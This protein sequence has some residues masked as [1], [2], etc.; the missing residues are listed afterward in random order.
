M[1]KKMNNSRIVLSLSIV[2]LLVG[3]FTSGGMAIGNTMMDELPNSNNS[4]ASSLGQNLSM[5]TEESNVF[6][7]DNQSQTIPTMINNNLTNNQNSSSILTPPVEAETTGTNELSSPI[8]NL[9]MIA[10]VINTDTPL[11]GNV[12]VSVTF[13]NE[14]GFETQNRTITAEDSIQFP[15]SIPYQADA[16]TANVCAIV[17][18]EENTCD[19]LALNPEDDKV[20]KLNLELINF[21]ALEPTT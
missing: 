3:I 7:S 4:S 15:L 17:N 5:T 18:G 1:V 16:Q 11:T 8:E 21:E 9:R 14:V 19:G 2:A 12:Y 20:I 6:T 13:D 10:T